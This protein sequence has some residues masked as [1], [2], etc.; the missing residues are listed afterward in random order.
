[1]GFPAALEARIKGAKFKQGAAIIRTAPLVRQ[2]LDQGGYEIQRWGVRAAKA[3]FHKY[4]DTKTYGFFIV[5]SVQRTTECVL[6][7]W[8][9]FEAGGALGLDLSAPAAAKADMSLDYF[10]A[11]ETAGW[12]VRPSNLL[13]ATS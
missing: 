6:K 13:Q 2:S 9:K 11:Y 10:K 4:P 12:V 7:Y 8:S 5:T 3:V 1:M